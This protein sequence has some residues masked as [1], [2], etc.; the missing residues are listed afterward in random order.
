[1]TRNE[2]EAES[3][4]KWI[5]RLIAPREEALVD[6]GAATYEEYRAACGYIAGMRTVRNELARRNKKYETED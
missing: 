4:L 6:G 1:M 5:D 2:T 3:L